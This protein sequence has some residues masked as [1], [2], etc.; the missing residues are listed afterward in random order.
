MPNMSKESILAELDARKVGY[1]EEM[2][3]NEL[4]KLYKKVID[5]EK[6]EEQKKVEQPEA[7]DY[8]GVLC[9]ISTIHD[10]HRR[11]TLLERK[12]NAG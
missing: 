10:L 11:V 5:E 2:P 7:I 9:G 4:V 8:T 12:I 3:Y 1:S 6:A